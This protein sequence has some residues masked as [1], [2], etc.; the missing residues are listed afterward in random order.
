M[1][2]NLLTCFL[3]T[4]L[5][6]ARS[7]TEAC[8]RARTWL[9]E[10]SIALEGMASSMTYTVTETR[11]VVPAPTVR[12]AWIAV[13]APGNASG[14]L[15]EKELACMRALSEEA[16]KLLLERAGLPGSDAIQ[17]RMRVERR[18]WIV[19]EAG[20]DEFYPGDLTPARYDILATPHFKLLHLASNRQATLLPA[21]APYFLA[22]VWFILRPLTTGRMGPRDEPLAVTTWL[23][24]AADSEAGCS[25]GAQVFLRSVEGSSLRSMIMLPDWAPLPA[26]YLEFNREHDRFLSFELTYA[27]TADGPSLAEVLAVQS[28]GLEELDIRLYTFGA[29]TMASP[30][31]PLAFPVARDCRLFDERTGDVVEHRGWNAWP[32]FLRAYT[33]AVTSGGEIGKGPGRGVSDG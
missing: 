28:A 22:D 25:G 23:W 24:M 19:H 29:W 8:A 16:R 14:W 6:H 2:G 20:R 10:C 33:W 13:A 31:E 18:G 27:E 17:R 9:E 4:V 3:V 15:T 32:E 1:I 21:D 26:Q 11:V 12:H 5:T 7:T 30:D